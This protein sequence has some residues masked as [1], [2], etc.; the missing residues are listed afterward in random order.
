[1]TSS[2]APVLKNAWSAAT[3]LAGISAM[4]QD[5]LKVIKQELPD[6]PK[7]LEQLQQVGPRLLFSPNPSCSL[8]ATIFL[9]MLDRFINLSSLNWT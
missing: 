9:L 1:M 3:L 5:C 8:Y 4:D 2:P 7:E 6:D